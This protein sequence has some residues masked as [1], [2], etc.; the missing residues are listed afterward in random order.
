MVLIKGFEQDPYLRVKTVHPS[1]D[2]D[3][4]ATYIEEEVNNDQNAPDTPYDGENM[5]ASSGN[6]GNNYKC[7]PENP[8]DG[9]NMNDYSN[10]E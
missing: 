3:S 4:K 8:Y 6:E 5:N 10:N 9:E 1:I 7:A 2:D